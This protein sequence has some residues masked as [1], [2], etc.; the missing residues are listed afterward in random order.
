MPSVLVFV[1]DVTVTSHYRILILLLILF[2][3]KLI[4]I[5]NNMEARKS[6]PTLFPWGKGG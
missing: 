3:T 4:A 5:F 1:V 6:L 2:R